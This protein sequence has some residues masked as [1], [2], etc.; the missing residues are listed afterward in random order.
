MQLSADYVTSE[1]PNCRIFMLGDANELKIEQIN[2]ALG[3]K[4]LVKKPT[5]KGDTMLDLISSNLH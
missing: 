3:L 4:K 1:Y 5:T 2:R